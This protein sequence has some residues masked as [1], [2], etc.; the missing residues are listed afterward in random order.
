M[1]RPL[2]PI[3]CALLIHAHCFPAVPV[4]YVVVNP[5]SG[6]SQLSREEVRNIF[7]GRQ[8]SLVPGVAAIPVEQQDLEVRSSFYRLL[9]KKELAEINA[10]WAPVIVHRPG[11]SPPEG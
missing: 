6:V 2:L 4:L 11:P 1:R 7:L 3:L 10:Y 9:V 5:D 8:K